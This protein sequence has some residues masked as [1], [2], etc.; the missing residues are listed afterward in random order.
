MATLYVY[1]LE[2]N[3]LVARINGDSQAACE[4]KADEMYGASNDHGRTWSPA[5][6]F[7]GGLEPGEDVLDIDA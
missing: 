3:Q 7:A 2:T 4:A 5:F 6:G 1:S